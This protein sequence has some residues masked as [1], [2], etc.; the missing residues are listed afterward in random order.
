M[1]FVNFLSHDFSGGNDVHGLN[2][3]GRLTDARFS[4]KGRCKRIPSR[5]TKFKRVR[6]FLST[7]SYLYFLNCCMIAY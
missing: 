1:N 6:V 4:T 3:L 7:T 5:R 2:S